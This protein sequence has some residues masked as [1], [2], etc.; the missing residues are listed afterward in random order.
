M[1]TAT[2]FYLRVYWKCIELGEFQIWKAP[3]SCAIITLSRTVILPKVGTIQGMR[4][5]P[6]IYYANLQV[7]PSS[8]QNQLVTS[9]GADCLHSLWC[10]ARQW[11]CQALTSA[12][13]WRR[14]TLQTLQRKRPHPAHSEKENQEHGHQAFDIR[15]PKRAGDTTVQAAA[16]TLWGT[17]E[18]TR[19]SCKMTFTGLSTPGGYD[20]ERPNFT[21]NENFKLLYMLIFCLQWRLWCS[22]QLPRLHSPKNKKIMLWILFLIFKMTHSWLIQR[23]FYGSLSIWKKY[24]SSNF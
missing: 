18:V 5:E 7:L 13:L 4:N 6:P 3:K 24:S 22:L 1:K 9:L 2:V 23:E 10:S 8:H 16:W 17:H 20:Y 21:Q 19:L 11:K 14:P 12:L 15:K